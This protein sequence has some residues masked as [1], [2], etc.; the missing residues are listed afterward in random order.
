MLLLRIPTLN[1]VEESLDEECEVEN[2]NEGL[3]LMEEKHVNETPEEKGIE[4]DVIEFVM[5]KGIQVMD[6]EDLIDGAVEPH[7]VEDHH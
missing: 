1:L 2:V 6:V 3:E 5:P 7:E 4:L